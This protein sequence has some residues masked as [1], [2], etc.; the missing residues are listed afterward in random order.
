MLVSGGQESESVIC[1]H[2][3]ILFQILSPC[4]L[5]QGIEKNSLCYT[6]G[7]C[8]GIC[9]IYSSESEVAQV[10]PTLC[11]PMDCSLPLLRL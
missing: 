10:C 5:L 7:P 4:R 6:V 1:V 11:D 8:W 2:I 3:F 9:F